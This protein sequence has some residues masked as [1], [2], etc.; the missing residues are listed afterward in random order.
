MIN[1]FIAFDIRNNSFSSKTL[2]EVIVT[3]E[4]VLKRIGANEFC[5]L[6]RRLF[7]VSDTMTSWITYIDLTTTTDIFP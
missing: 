3:I 4:K 1:G 5:R 6:S 7:D 2:T